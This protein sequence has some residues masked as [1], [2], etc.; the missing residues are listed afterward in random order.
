MKNEFPKEHK[1]IDLELTGTT[2]HIVYHTFCGFRLKTLLVSLPE[3]VRCVSTEDGIK[4]VVSVGNCFAPLE[5]WKKL[6]SF[7][8]FKKKLPQ[9]LGI[10]K[11]SSSILYTARDMDTL[12]VKEERWNHIEVCVMATAGAEDNAL[13]VGVDKASFTEEKAGHFK[14]LGTV[15]IIALTNATLSVPA[16][17]RSI[18]TITEAKTVAF[19][20]LSVRSSYNPELLATGTGTDGVIIASG[21]GPEITY[22]G[23]H[24]LFGETLARLTTGAV[25]EALLKKPKT[26]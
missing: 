25:K 20:D 8:S 2:A 5:F 9:E 17:L 23:G 7:R 1:K 11:R 24:S 3:P 16:M 21:K 18:I 6:R 26:D 15:N 12:S 14:S 4:K 13:R 10:T 22:T 19:Q